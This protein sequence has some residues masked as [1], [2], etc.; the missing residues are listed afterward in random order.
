MGVIEDLGDAVAGAGRLA[1]PSVVRIGQD[2]GRGAGVIVRTGLVI[3]SAHNLRGS[4]T[5]VTFADGRQVTGEVTA[6]DVEGDLAVLAVDTADASAIRWEP[7][8]RLK[9]GQLVMA[10]GPARFQSPGRVT[11]GHVS[12][13]GVAFRGPRGRL[14]EDA[15]EHTALVGRGT[16][17]GPVV[18][19]RGFLVGIN[20]HRPGDG[21]YLAIA[22]DSSVAARVDALARG[23]APERRRLGIALV[24]RP[25][26]RRLRAAVGLEPRDG[27]LVRQVDPDGPAAAGG[28][29]AGDLIVAAGGDQIGDIGQLLVAVE[30]HEGGGPLRLSLLRGAEELSVD[31]S[32][33]PQGEVE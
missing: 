1:G 25:V 32:F 17:G 21:L 12:A 16:S 9:L 10:L 23:Q 14:I 4:T 20:T 29:Q 31:V 27:L 26:A 22:T 30:G 11:A 18:D 6:A 8:G 19:A 7:D 5:T 15:F 24:P 33:D 2:G 28:V 13:L 3:T